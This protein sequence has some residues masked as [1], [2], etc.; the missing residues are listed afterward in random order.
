MISDMKYTDAI[1]LS[2]IGYG[3]YTSAI[4]Q[5]IFYNKPVVIRNYYKNFNDKIYSKKMISYNYNDSYKKILY[6][7]KN[8]SKVQ[9]KQFKTKNLI[10]DKKSKNLSSEILK[11]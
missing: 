6:I 4:D 11:I 7:S 9:K 5:M 2:D 3:N 8:L 1:N 10:F